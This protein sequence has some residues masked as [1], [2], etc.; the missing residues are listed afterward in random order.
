MMIISPI[1]GLIE[2]RRYKAQATLS[3][4]MAL[5]GRSA[6]PLQCLGLVL[7][8]SLACLMHGALACPF[9]PWLDSYVTFYEG[10]ICG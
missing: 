3:F 2:P 10:D 5:L 4:R 1:G 8:N 7:L 6:I 9:P